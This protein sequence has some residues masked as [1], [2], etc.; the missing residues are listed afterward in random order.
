MIVRQ[1]AADYPGCPEVFRRHSESA[2]RPTLFG[3]LE[4]LNRFARRRGIALGSLL[5]ELAEA[6]GADVSRD[7]RLA[8]EPH[9]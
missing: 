2:H 3:H 1:V 5:S 4:P 6:Y 9:L 7:Y 8:H